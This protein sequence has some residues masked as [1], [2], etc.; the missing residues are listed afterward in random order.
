MPTS[1]P[2]VPEPSCQFA[3]ADPFASLWERHQDELGCPLSA[4]PEIIQDA[5]QEFERGCMFWRQDNDRIYAVYE[6]GAKA[7]TYEWFPNWDG[8]DY[9]CDHSPPA[10]KFL[11]T[12]GFGWVWCTQIADPIHTMG[13]GLAGEVGY[14]PGSGDPLVQEFEQ[15]FIFR[16]NAGRTDS[17][18]YIFLADGTVRRERY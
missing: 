5:E 16:H 17:T 2:T 8:G 11:P 13:W 7:G 15:G 9:T 3:V 10:G 6:G 14:G 4:E 12:R 1:T 18:A